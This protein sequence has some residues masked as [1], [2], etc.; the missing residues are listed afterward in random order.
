MFSVQVMDLLRTDSEDEEVDADK[1]MQLVEEYLK[2]AK[3]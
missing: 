1:G 2:T 3:C